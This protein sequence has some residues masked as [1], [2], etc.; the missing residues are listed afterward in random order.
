MSKLVFSWQYGS[1]FGDL[2]KFKVINW[3]TREVNLRSAAMMAN[4]A[5]VWTS[6]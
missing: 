1:E 3:S 2:V 4:E 5:L 6:S